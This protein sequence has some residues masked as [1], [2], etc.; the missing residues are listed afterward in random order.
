MS[1]MS[2]KRKRRKK[3]KTISFYFL[4]LL[5]IS[6]RNAQIRTLKSYLFI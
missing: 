3:S 4:L 5:Q 1:H 6:S 2:L